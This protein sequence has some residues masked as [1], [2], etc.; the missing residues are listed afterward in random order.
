MEHM[1]H[2]FESSLGVEDR[3]HTKSLRAIPQKTTILDEPL[4]Q[5]APFEHTRARMIP[6]VSERSTFDMIEADDE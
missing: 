4:V 2:L 1:T 3:K 5:D 6:G